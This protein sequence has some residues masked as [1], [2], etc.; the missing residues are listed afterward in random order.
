[1][2]VSAAWRVHLTS[3]WRLALQALPSQPWKSS[4]MTWLATQSLCFVKMRMSIS[5]QN[6]PD[7]RMSG[8]CDFVERKSTDEPEFELLIKSVSYRNDFGFTLGASASSAAGLFRALRLIGDS[9][10][11]QDISQL[12]RNVRIL[13]EKLL[14][15]IGSEGGLERSFSQLHSH[16]FTL[17]VII[18]L[19][20]QTIDP[21]PYELLPYVQSLFK[22]VRE[23]EHLCYKTPTQ[24]IRRSVADITLW[25]IFVAAVECFREEEMEIAKGWMQSVIASGIGNRKDVISVVMKVWETREELRQTRAL[26]LHVGCNWYRSNE[27]HNLNYHEVE[28]GLTRVSWQE[29]MRSQGVDLL[30]I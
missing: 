9:R 29:A 17:G 30:L 26:D 12:R 22:A 4:E 6:H 19:N 13:T 27:P 8:P 14:S 25:P 7:T 1:M 2:G 24:S 23:F 5:D 3:A 21:S 11:T 10:D 28:R 18:F 16:I 15:S 20:R